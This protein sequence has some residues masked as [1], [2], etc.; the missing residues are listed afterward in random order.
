MR[1]KA[2]KERELHTRQGQLHLVHASN[3]K[4]FDSQDRGRIA[5]PYPL[6][7]RLH[8]PI[9]RDEEWGSQKRGLHLLVDGLET[10][11]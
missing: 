6:R 7:R 9:G 1:R 11:P 4:L 8:W 5:C 2:C 3:L 10:D